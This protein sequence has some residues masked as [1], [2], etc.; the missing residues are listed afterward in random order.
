MV[1]FVNLVP[2]LTDVTSTH[3]QNPNHGLSPIVPTS[4]TAIAA[5]AFIFCLQAVSR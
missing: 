4:N 2:L 3:I 1:H 5:L